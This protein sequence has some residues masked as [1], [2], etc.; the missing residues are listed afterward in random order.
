M[1]GRRLD[2]HG[3]LNAFPYGFDHKRSAQ[4]K[5][6]GWAPKKTMYCTIFCKYLIIV[7]YIEY[8]DL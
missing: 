7:V 1:V 8:F 5:D 2:V 3:V 4:I 6:Y